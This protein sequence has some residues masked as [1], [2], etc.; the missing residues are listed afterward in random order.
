V[1]WSNN[2]EIKQE[3]EKK[4]RKRAICYDQCFMLY[5]RLF[6]EQHVL[7]LFHHLILE[8]KIVD[9][10]YFHFYFNFNYSGTKN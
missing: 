1:L 7:G 5:R 6:Y 9:S 2:S 4:K 8:L 10:N 3:K